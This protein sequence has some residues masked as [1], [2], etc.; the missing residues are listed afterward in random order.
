MTGSGI[1]VGLQLGTQPPLGATRAYLVG[2]RAMRLDS[3]MLIDHFQNVFP[4]V[5][6]D[7]QLTWLAAQHPT[8]HEFFDYQVLFGFLASRVGRMRLGVGVT[9]SIR[10][11]PVLIAQAIMTLSHLTKRAP[12][13]GIGAGERMN[14]D[15]YGLDPTGP[16]GRLEE[17]L[18]I[19]RL[20]LSQR[21]PITFS[22]RHFRLERAPMDLK[23]APG[24][25]PEIWIA[26]HGS[27]MLALTGRYG[28]G[29]Y[30]TAVVSPREYAD[31]LATVRAAA[32]EAGRDPASIT[33]ALHRFAVIA[34]TE[35]EAR[36]MLRTKVIRSLGLMAPSDLWRQAGTVHPFGE[37]FNPLVDFVPGDYD[38][39]TMDAAIAAVPDDLVSEGPLLWGAPDQ[40]VARL[41][42]FGDA[43]MRH[44]VL[45]PVS[46]LVSKR[47]ALYGL[48][49]TGRIA[50]SL[51]GIAQHGS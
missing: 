15:P 46:G 41:R 51:R 36:A 50:R 9:E 40:V 24:R 48:W 23:P 27:R 4:S 11:H 34:P 38:R 39:A 13:L 10:R 1:A 29:W 14:I 33:P 20:C 3:V 37:H 16:V 35:R 12:I 7:R 42:A 49:A 25:A 18:Q 26:G 22:G 32:G 2:A 43:G 17:A 21:G 31:K 6:W 5:I 8:P 19:I 28:D 45:A 47:A 44:V 30:P